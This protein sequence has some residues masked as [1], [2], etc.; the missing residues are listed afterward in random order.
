[1]T[2]VFKL[3][4]EIAIMTAIALL[5]VAG[6]VLASEKEDLANDVATGAL[7]CLSAGVILRLVQYFAIASD[8]GDDEEDDMG[9]D[10][11]RL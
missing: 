7:Y 8:E 3:L 5:L 4:S 2:E 6:I 9:D 1:M 11:W 10:N